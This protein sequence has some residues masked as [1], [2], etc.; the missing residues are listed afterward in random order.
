M[1]AHG[2]GYGWVWVGGMKNTTALIGLILSA[3]VLAGFY[4]CAVAPVVH[5]FPNLGI[6]VIS[7][8]GRTVELNCP[9]TH[10]DKGETIDHFKSHIVG[11]WKEAFREIWVD[12]LFPE[13]L[14]HELCHADGQPDDVCAGIRWPS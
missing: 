3:L 8:D 7:A 4:G 6:T 13:V 5:V 14:F 10:N 9:S 12:W 11:C 2:F 1:D